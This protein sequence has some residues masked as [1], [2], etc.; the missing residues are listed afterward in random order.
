MACLNSTGRITLPLRWG[1]PVARQ[2]PLWIRWEEYFP[3]YFRASRFE[4][5]SFLQLGAHCGKNTYSCA[6]GGDPIW[7]YA[8]ACGWKG[9]AVEPVSYVFAK[10]CYN[11]LRWPAVVPLRGACWSAPGQAQI[12]LGFGEDNWLALA[13]RQGQRSRGAKSQ[14]VP[15]LTLAELWQAALR[16]SAADS[17]HAVA[18]P[19]APDILVMD[20]EGAEA[21]CLL[22]G[23]GGGGSS[24]AE[25][26]AVWSPLAMLQPPPTLILFEAVWL[27]AANMSAIDAYLRASGYRMLAALPNWNPQTNSPHRFAANRLYGL[28]VRNRDGSVSPKGRDTVGGGWAGPSASPVT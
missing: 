20:V 27:T 13:P 19:R 18:L 10:L 16:A 5:V 8:T 1:D 14:R 21:M 26:S 9:V 23:S 12:S 11:Y 28:K 7:S 6:G 2:V 3:K 4:D 22:G 15:L 17:E 24:G 25:S